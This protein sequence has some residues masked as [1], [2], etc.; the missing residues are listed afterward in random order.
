MDNEVMYEP[1]IEYF[2]DLFGVAEKFGGTLGITRDG[3][4]V[5]ALPEPNAVEVAARITNDDFPYGYIVPGD[6]S[7]LVVEA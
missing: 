4:V 6:D 1:D 3:R 2:E 7:T 5:I